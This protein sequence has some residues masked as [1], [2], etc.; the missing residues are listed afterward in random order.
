MKTTNISDISDSQD[1]NN[2]SGDTP[3]NGIIE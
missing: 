3:G 1:K 2:H